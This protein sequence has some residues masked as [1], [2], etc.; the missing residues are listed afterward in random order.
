M[1]PLIHNYS[2][3]AGR[4]VHWDTSDNKNWYLKNLESPEARQRLADLGFIDTQID[5]IYNSY[6]FRTAEFNRQFDVVCF[7][8]SFTMGTG[9]HSQ[10]T[11][12]AQLQA[13][14]GLQVANLGHAGSSNDTAFRFASYY[15]KFLKPRYAVWL[16]TDMHRVELLDDNVPMSLNIM[17]A[18]TK[19]P[20]ADDYFIKT[21]FT[22]Q[23]NQQLNFQKNTLAFK[24]LCQTLGIE[25]VILD[26]SQVETR[27]FPY[28]DARDLIHPGATTYRA[29]AQQVKT[30]LDG[31][32]GNYSA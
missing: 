19:N 11:W 22:S 1:T 24:Y 17:A 3:L 10:D 7:G 23:T 27:P 18:D 32:S 16:Q 2:I 14:T 15:L 9:I 5:Y 13:M 29:L 31:P 20:C 6:G 4:T 12:P 26:R 25:S 8:C 28:G 21:W 30:I